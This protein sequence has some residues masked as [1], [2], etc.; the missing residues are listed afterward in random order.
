MR[1]VPVPQFFQLLHMFFAY[2]FVAA[3]VENNAR[4]IAIVDYRIAHKLDTLLP[5]P[6][7]GIFLGIT[8]GHRLH[9]PYPVAGLDILFP[10][11]HV[12]PAHKIAVALNYHAVA[13]IAH[14][15]RY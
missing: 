1:V 15:R 12:H 13:E 4:V 9:Q 6:L 14:P 5:L 3:F 7:P 2:N 11:C 8:G 10:R